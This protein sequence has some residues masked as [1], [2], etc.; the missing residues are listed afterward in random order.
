MMITSLLSKNNAEFRYVR[1][2]QDIN[3]ATIDNGCYF[4][5]LQVW[6]KSGRALVNEATGKLVTASFV[7]TVGSL[8]NITDD[9]IS[10]YSGTN[11]APSPH[12][13]QLDL[14]ML[15]L[16]GAPGQYI[17]ITGYWQ[18][19]YKHQRVWVELSQDADHWVTIFDTNYSGTYTET[20]TG[21]IIQL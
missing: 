1:W 7:P 18:G 13:V 2:W 12:Y 17:M 19:N 16:R 5:E 10:S 15:K 9:N 14:E 6:L 4:G 20:E 3:I 21:K 8:A 11:S